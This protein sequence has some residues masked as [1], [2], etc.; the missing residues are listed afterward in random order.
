MGVAPGFLIGR[1]ARR[2][3]PYAPASLRE[4]P[5]RRATRPSMAL[6]SGGAQLGSKRAIDWAPSAA[7]TSGAAVTVP[8]VAPT[9]PLTRPWIA[10][11]DE[12]SKAVGWPAAPLACCSDTQ[13]FTRSGVQWRS[14]VT[15]SGF[16]P[17]AF[18]T[19]RTSVRY[20]GW[21]PRHAGGTR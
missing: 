16:T 18:I 1:I 21:S 4:V 14:S 10:R 19:K 9:S 8:D 20:A 13:A 12:G 6:N 5:G 17:G 11:F 15:G 2:D 3:L 7:A